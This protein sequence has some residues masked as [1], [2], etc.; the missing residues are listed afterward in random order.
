MTNEDQENWKA[1]LIEEINVLQ[2]ENLALKADNI[3][4][5]DVIRNLNTEVAVLKIKLYHSETNHGVKH[6]V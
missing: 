4:L 3:I 2:E 6:I 5:K 1:T